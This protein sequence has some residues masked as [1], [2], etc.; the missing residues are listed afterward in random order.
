M[1]MDTPGD[2]ICS[3][4]FGKFNFHKNKV[5]RVPIIQNFFS[6]FKGKNCQI[7]LESCETNP[8]K[9]DALCFIHEDS[10]ECYCVPD[11]HGD[12][13]QYKYNDCLLPPLPK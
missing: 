4:P 8:C 5:G 3:C 13:C 9:N 11:F 6:G 2:Y 7:V 10:Y 12:R 1:C